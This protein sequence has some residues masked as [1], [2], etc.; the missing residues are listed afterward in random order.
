[1]SGFFCTPVGMVENEDSRLSLVFV[2]F[3]DL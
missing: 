2:S 1:M 3:A